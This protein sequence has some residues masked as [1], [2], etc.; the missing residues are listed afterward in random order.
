MPVFDETAATPDS[1]PAGNGRPQ[2]EQQEPASIRRRG[3]RRAF[4]VG[5]KT[6]QS[7]SD[8]V[9]ELD[10]ISDGFAGLARRIGTI[11]A[12]IRVQGIEIEKREKA[13]HHALGA[14]KQLQVS[15]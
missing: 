6:P 3:R 14:L 1:Q 13:V 5:Q 8:V 7:L 10:A 9:A 11:Q 15:A 2:N 4:H 12:S